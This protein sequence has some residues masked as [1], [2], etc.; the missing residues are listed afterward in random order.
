MKGQPRVPEIG[1]KK[2]GKRN[3]RKRKT[4]EG[5]FKAPQKRIYKKASDKDRKNT[6]SSGGNG[7]QEFTY[8]GK[9]DTMKTNGKRGKEK[10]KPT[11]KKQ[12]SQEEKRREN[13]RHR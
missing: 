6:S 4:Q 10:V 7:D 9:K 3:G 12:S 2:R 5:R 1:M 8:Y 13:K 11:R